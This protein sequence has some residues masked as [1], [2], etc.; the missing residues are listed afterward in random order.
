MM[1][2]LCDLTLRDVNAHSSLFTSLKEDLISVPQTSLAHLQMEVTGLL[3]RHKSSLG[4]LPPHTDAKS[5]SSMY[6]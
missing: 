3:L 5:T 4:S 2:M 6:C 1:L